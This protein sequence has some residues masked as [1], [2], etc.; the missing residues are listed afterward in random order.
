MNAKLR[1]IRI[2]QYLLMILI[3]INIISSFGVI[4]F[5]Y[6]QV[7]EAEKTFEDDFYTQ[8]LHEGH[9]A[10]YWFV[11]CVIIM[12][13]ADCICCVGLF[14]VYK[15]NNHLTLIFSAMMFVLAV[16][17][18]WDKYMRGSVASFALPLLT[19]LVGLL[20]TTLSY[21]YQ[22]QSGELPDIKYVKR[23]PASP[24]EKTYAEA[25]KLNVNPDNSE[26][27]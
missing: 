13:L 19:G 9:Y 3:G 26:P 22:D 5:D 21:D 17:G 25:V 7:K 16:Y 2:A 4:A 23:E 18:A 14:A 20:Y 15:E 11:S 6:F 12:V 10:K 8:E 1:N 24:T 27:E